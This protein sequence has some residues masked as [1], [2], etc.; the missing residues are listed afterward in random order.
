MKKVILKIEGMSCSA[1]SNTIEKYL[2]KHDGI[3]ATVNLVMASALIYY[4]EE[5]VTLEDLNKYIEESGYKSLGIYNEQEEQRNDNTK[6]YLIIYG[7][8]I[9]VLML[10]C[11][12]H[13][14]LKKNPVIYSLT[15]FL[16]MVV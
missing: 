16:K 8:L 14:P 15:T 10:L 13:N 9:I 5:K 3:D 4:D 6:F 7:T 11:L 12:T 1:C 2:N